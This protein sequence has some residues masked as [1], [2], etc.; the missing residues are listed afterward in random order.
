MTPREWMGLHLHLHLNRKKRKYFKI[1]PSMAFNLEMLNINQTLPRILNQPTYFFNDSRLHII[2]A[3]IPK[4]LPPSFSQHIRNYRVKGSWVLFSQEVNEKC[5]INHKMVIS[6]Y[7]VI[8]F[9]SWNWRRINW[10]QTRRWMHCRNVVASFPR[11]QN[12]EINRFKMRK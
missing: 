10:Y 6:I 9:I 3:R 1:E 11:Y 7:K 8:I 5:I 4:T 12:M 2:T